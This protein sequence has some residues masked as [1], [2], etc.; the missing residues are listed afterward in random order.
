MSEGHE[1]G[2]WGRDEGRDEGR[3]VFSKRRKGV[4]VENINI[5][6]FPDISLDLERIFGED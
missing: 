1:R 5:L 2:S 4:A 3:S 6:K